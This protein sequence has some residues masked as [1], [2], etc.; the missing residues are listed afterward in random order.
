M[1]PAGT[2]LSS[3]HRAKG[4]EAKRVF[5]L[6]PDLMPHPKAKSEWE[7]GQEKNLQYVAQTRAIEELVFVDGKF[8]GEVDNG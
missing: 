2:L 4:M 6:R 7:M 8:K 5:I 1:K 3:I